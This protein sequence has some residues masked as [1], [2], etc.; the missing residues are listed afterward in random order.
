MQLLNVEAPPKRMGQNS[1]RRGVLRISSPEQRDIFR[2]IRRRNKA[3]R[4]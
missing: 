2:I 4:R 1:P 3:Y